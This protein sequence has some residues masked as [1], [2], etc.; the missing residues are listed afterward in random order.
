MKMNGGQM[1]CEALLREGVDVMFGIPGGAILPFYQTLPQFPKLRHI[2]VRHEQGATHAADGYYRVSGKVGVA[3]GTSG[4]GST[5]M[6][7]GIACAQTDS[8]PM[9][10]I[11]GQVA[12]G[13]IGTDAFQ[14]TDVIGASM[15]L[16]KHSYQV[17]R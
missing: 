17:M 13:A 8:V 14:E 11:T 4:P 6:L 5:N 1:M 3:I 9:V 12:R 10:C 7:T 16:V 15:P 2:L